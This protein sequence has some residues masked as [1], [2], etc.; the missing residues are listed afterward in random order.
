MPSKNPIPSSS[1]GFSTPLPPLNALP[2]KPAGPKPSVLPIQ[3]PP[4]T[5]RPLAF[6]TFTKK[7]NLTLTSAALGQLAAFIGKH[8]GTGWREEGLAEGVLEEVAKGWKKGG[9][10]VIVGGD[11][12]GIQLLDSILKSVE[13]VM[14]G[15]KV[16]RELSRVGSFSFA[17]GDAATAGEVPRTLGERQPS[18]GLSGLKVQESNEDEDD[19]LMDPREWLQVLS[20]FE[21]PRMIYNVSSKNFDLSPTKPTLFPPPSHRTSLFRSRYHLVHQRILRNESFQPPSLTAHN[22]SPS[23]NNKITPIA[24]LLGRTGSTHLLFGLL[25][26]TATGVL[27]LADTTGTIVLDVTHAQSLPKDAVWYTPGMLV[28]V[29]GQYREDFGTASAGG[30]ILGDS[31]GVGGTINGTFAASVLGHP[32]CERRSE[33]LGIQ[34]PSNANVSGPGFGWT[35]FLGVG[36]ERATGTRMRRIQARVL[37]AMRQQQSL[38]GSPDAMDVDEDA[39]ADE[40]QRTIPRTLLSRRASPTVAVASGLNLSSPHT[41]PALRT[42]FSTYDAVPPTEIPLAIVLC[43]P[44]VSGAALSGAVGSGSI[45]YKEGFDQLAGLLSDFPG[46][47]ARTSL[48]FVPGDG[49]AW[50][51]AFGGG[52]SVPVPRKGVPDLFTRRVKRA[53]ADANR[54]IWGATVGEASNKGKGAARSKHGDVSWTSNP[55]RLAWFGCVGEMVVFRDDVLGRLRRLGIRLGGDEAPDEEQNEDELESGSSQTVQSTSADDAAPNID[56]DVET[57]RRLTKTL[58]DQGNLAPFPL[59]HRPVHWDYGQALSLYPLPSAVVLA[60]SEAPAFSLNYMSCC[61]MN[62]GDIVEG[63]GSVR[64]AKWVEYDISQNRGAVRIEG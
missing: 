32:P 49:D 27:A 16:V 4:S 17:T 43:G 54:E 60:D 46:V 24:N 52:T 45:E 44:F 29:D 57:A 30:D 7:H 11:D 55:S 26:T 28:L 42:L 6:R 61:V 5:L 40:S 51:S 38:D 48:V 59:E 18:F 14:S 36:S 23:Y 41:L 58:L 64:R 15:G 34:D 1:P 19:H 12:K 35:D 37:A 50:T 3:L 22:S 39:D 47:L 63:Q 62:P 31:G 53:V 9:G 56:P 21:Q 20:A 2:S 10:S 25:T 13:G 8:C 33:T